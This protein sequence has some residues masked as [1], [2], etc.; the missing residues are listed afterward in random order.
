[1]K[2]IKSK[3]IIFIFFCALIIFLICFYI[4]KATY[5]VFIKA[6]GNINDKNLT[7]IIDPGH[8]G[9]DG[10]STSTY[11]KLPEKAINLE[12]SKSLNM[13]F[14]AS[15]YQTIMTRNS[16]N[17]IS[18]NEST[19]RKRKIS[20]M[21]NRLKIAN[22]E[23]NAVLISIHQN[24]FEDNKSSG[25][26]V[27]FSTN[28]SQSEILAENIQNSLKINLNPSNERKIKP[29]DK[30]IYLLYNCK[31]PAVLVECGFLSNLQEAQKLNTKEYQKQIAF[32]IYNGFCEYIKDHI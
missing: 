5:K 15:G 14:K 27:F 31:C 28:N 2:N 19:I 16:D 30:N 25:S 20:D 18:E 26:Q 17:D 4:I 13:L 22:E 9:E 7:I 3:K 21:K 24:K 29:A 12:I 6:S 11:S 1:M 32:G 8:G 23:T 10:G